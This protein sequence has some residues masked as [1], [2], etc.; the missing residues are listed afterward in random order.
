M[1]GTEEYVSP[2]ILQKKQV[3]YATD[4]WSLGIIIYQM[5]TPGKTPFKGNSE[6]ITFQNILQ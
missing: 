5:Y 4:L 3:S 1:V 6:Y 2:E